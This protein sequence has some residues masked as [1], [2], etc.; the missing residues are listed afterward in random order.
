MTSYN[1]SNSSY[2]AAP[3]EEKQPLIPTWGVVVGVVVS[4]LLIGGTIALVI[5]LAKNYAGQIEAIRDIFIILFALAA[6]S[7]VVVLIMLLVAI[8]RLINMLEFEI[9]PILEKT[10][11]TI[12]MVQGTTT[13]VSANVVKPAITASGYIAAVRGMMGALFGN[14]RRN[15]PD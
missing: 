15:L 14:P 8:I 13:F 2:P 9:K 6:C 4:I 11:E 10:N 7:S 5:W 3:P 1:P 12:S